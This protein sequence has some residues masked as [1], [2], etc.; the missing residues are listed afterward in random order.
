MLLKSTEVLV[1]ECAAVIVL[2]GI[3]LTIADTPAYPLAFGIEIVALFAVVL[4]ST[5]TKVNP[6][7][8][9]NWL[10]NPA[11]SIGG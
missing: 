9:L 11:A 10:A 5:M 4:D 1:L 8:L 7:G 2:A 3:L 6:T